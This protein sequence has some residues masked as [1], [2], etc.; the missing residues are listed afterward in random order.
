MEALLEY[1]DLLLFAVLLLAGFGFGTIAEKR[2]YA[3]IRKREKELR[4]IILVPEKRLPRQDCDTAFVCGSA[5]IAQ[6]YFKMTLASF[7]HIIGGRIGAYESLVERAR[8]EAILRMKHE[9]AVKRAKLIFNVKFSTCNL[10]GQEQSKKGCVEV[11]AYG[12]AVIP[13]GARA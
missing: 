9:A 10:M 2:H 12:T 6:D 7:V 1:F 5:V 3:S 4:N 11:T 8:R 13:H